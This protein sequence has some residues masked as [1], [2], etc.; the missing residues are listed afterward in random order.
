MAMRELARGDCV[1]LPAP[2]GAR[3]H[4]QRGE[5]F[6]VVLQADELAGLSTV[7]V[8]PTSTSAR[9]ATFRPQVRIDGV[10]T[11]VLIEQMRAVDH[12]RLGDLV[13]Q[14]AGSELVA[15]DEAIRLVLDISG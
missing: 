4:E 5:R 1:R 14:L 2:R 6:A 13:D 15:V 8:A 7:I 3:G 9:G 12:T 11:N 10:V